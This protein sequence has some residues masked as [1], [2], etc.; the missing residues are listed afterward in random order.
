MR[1]LSFTDVVVEMRMAVLSSSALAVPSAGVSALYSFS[2]M[3]VKRLAPYFALPYSAIKPLAFSLVIQ[4]MK[5]L[6]A[7]VFITTPDLG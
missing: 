6:A 1:P 7:S 3:R 5:T 2:S 4:L